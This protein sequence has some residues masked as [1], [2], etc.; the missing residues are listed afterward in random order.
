MRLT[1]YN[2]THKFYTDGEAYAVV[3]F[4]DPVPTTGT[5]SPSQALKEAGQEGVDWNL[6]FN[7]KNQTLADVRAAI[8][9]GHKA[10][11]PDC[12]LVYCEVLN[13]SVV[14]RTHDRRVLTLDEFC[15]EH[16][17]EKFQRMWKIHRT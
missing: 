15:A 16:S 1:H 12:E 6:A 9:F 11:H 7:T 17:D 14:V 4:F 2:D 13:G 3:P 8:Q 10:S 5:T